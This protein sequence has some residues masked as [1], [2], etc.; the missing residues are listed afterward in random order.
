MTK[1][2]EKPAEP[3]TFDRISAAADI[4][5]GEAYESVTQQA[6]NEIN[7]EP[8][9]GEQSNLPDDEQDVSTVA[10]NKDTAEE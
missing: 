5:F 3:T 7:N 4:N 1:K 10:A 6:A 9:E 2:K 8:L